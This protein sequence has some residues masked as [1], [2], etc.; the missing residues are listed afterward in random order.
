MAKPKGSNKENLEKTRAHLLA[1]ARQL[2]AEHGFNGTST[3]MLVDAAQS[4]RGALYH[5]FKDKTEIFRAVYDILCDE[6]GAVI[7]D[8]PYKGNNAVDD[9]IDGCIAYLEIFI[10][11]EFAQILLIDG[12]NVLGAEYCR[13]K[14]R[15]TAYKALAE[16]ITACG[17]D[18]Q[19]TVLI[20]DFFSGALDTY[21]LQIATAEDKQSAFRHYSE[22]FRILAYKLLK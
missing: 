17:T 15:E 13:S 11:P 21:A 14:D 10:R 16:G 4:S 1:I 20:T 9:L 8:Y 7:E 12:P 5:H 2:F 3:T 6:I 18:K 19:E 22:G